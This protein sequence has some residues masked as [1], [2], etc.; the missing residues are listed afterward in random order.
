MRSKLI[1]LG[2]WT[3]VCIGAWL[4]TPV[5]GTCD[6]G[7]NKNHLD[8]TA[9][10]FVDNDT[11]EINDANGVQVKNEGI[12]SAK[13]NKFVPYYVVPRW[14]VKVAATNNYTL[15]SQFSSPV[16][17]E[18]I[19]SFGSID[20][21]NGYTILADDSL[22]FEMKVYSAGARTVTQKLLGV[23]DVI[24]C[25]LNNSTTPI[26]SRT[27]SGWFPHSPETVTWNLVD[28]E[29]TLRIVV[30]DYGGTTRYVVLLGDIVDGSNVYFV[31]P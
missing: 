1:I 28:G 5:G 27:S 25:Y 29:N 14:T 2:L 26:Y 10:A 30:N 17:S 12:T 6:S 20:V 13:L 16:A 23:D 4:I 22:L 31:A 11:L 19:L 24:Y 9:K 7:I 21:G 8:K 15:P 18:S 3:A